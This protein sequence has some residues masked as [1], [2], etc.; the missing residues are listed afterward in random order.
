MEAAHN[1]REGEINIRRTLMIF[2]ELRNYSI[3]ILAH[4]YMEDEA[5]PLILSAGN[6]SDI[7]RKIEYI[8]CTRHRNSSAST[9]QLGR[10]QG[11]EKLVN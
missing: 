9:R 1:S 8:F 5:F 4:T 11:G 7:R 3:A 10:A 2:Y 6:L